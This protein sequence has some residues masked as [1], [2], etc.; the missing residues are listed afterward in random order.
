VKYVS[1][2]NALQALAV[3]LALPVRRALQALLGLPEQGP[4]QQAGAVE[5]PLPKVV[6][7][8]L[9]VLPQRMEEQLLSRR[10][11][12]AGVCQRVAVVVP[13]VWL[14]LLKIQR[15]LRGRLLP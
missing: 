10:K 13:A 11:T 12:K 1:K 3:V 8:R 9:E 14:I 5:V 2:I 15:G 7:H 6:R 4:V